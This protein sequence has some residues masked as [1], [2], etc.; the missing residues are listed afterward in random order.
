MIF[1]VDMG[2]RFEAAFGF[3]QCGIGISFFE[4]LENSLYIAV[5]LGMQVSATRGGKQI[6]NIFRRPMII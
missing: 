4:R 5:R 1:I 6:G 2:V 3:S